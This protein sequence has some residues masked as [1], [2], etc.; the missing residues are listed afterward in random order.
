MV[1]KFNKVMFAVIIQTHFDRYVACN[2]VSPLFGWE[3]GG[4]PRNPQFL[5]G[6]QALAKT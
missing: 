4:N 5:L 1:T 3:H 6:R 2:A